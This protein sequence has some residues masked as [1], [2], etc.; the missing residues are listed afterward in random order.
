MRKY[1]ITRTRR[2][3]FIGKL[4]LTQVD[5]D[6]SINWRQSVWQTSYRFITG[7]TELW[8]WFITDYNSSLKF[9]EII[10]SYSQINNRSFR[11]YNT[12]HDREYENTR[13]IKIYFHFSSEGKRFLYDDTC[14]KSLI[15]TEA[16]NL[17]HIFNLF[18]SGEK[19]CLNWRALI[20]N[21]HK[22]RK[23]LQSNTAK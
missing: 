16:Y 13:L 3:A 18:D 6:S 14:E 20:N 5:W 8:K 1:C 10:C 12:D 22:S 9:F 11:C 2:F 4:P 23:I 7:Q 15:Y 17:G 19:I 21:V